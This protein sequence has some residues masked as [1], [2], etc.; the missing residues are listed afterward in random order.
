LSL[1]G[2]DPQGKIEIDREK[3]RFF[4]EE[5]IRLAD[6][7]VQNQICVDAFLITPYRGGEEGADGKD[8]EQGNP[9]I[10][11]NHIPNLNHTLSLTLILS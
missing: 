3:E 11:P 2:T 7:C 6:L 8:K 1:K 5:Q 9:N 4:M 10:N